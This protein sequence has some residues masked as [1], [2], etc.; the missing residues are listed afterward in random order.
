MHLDRTRPFSMLTVQIESDPYVG[1]LYVGRKHSGI[2]RVGDMVLLSCYLCPSQ[3]DWDDVKL[4]SRQGGLIS[5]LED[6][7]E[8]GEDNRTENENQLQE[9][10]S[11]TGEHGKDIGMQVSQSLPIP[12]RESPIVLQGLRDEYLQ[13]FEEVDP[14]SANYTCNSYIY[15]AI[16][17]A[18]STHCSRGG[19]LDQLMEHFF[20]YR[21]TSDVEESLRRGK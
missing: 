2:L 20:G 1:M 8:L 7:S 6:D 3:I 9:E 18:I 14:V 11:T 16:E 21:P 5:E 4:C 10:G 17:I 13:A 12:S 19:I 15:E